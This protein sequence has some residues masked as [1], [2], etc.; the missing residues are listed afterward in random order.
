MSVEVVRIEHGH[1][2][3]KFIDFPH[4][5]YENDPY[6]VPEIYLSVSEILS[7]KKNPFFEHSEA[8]YF[9]AYRDQKLVGRIAAIHNKNYNE[10]HQSNVGFFGFFDF[11]DD[12]EVSGA[13]LKVAENWCKDKGLSSMLGPA[14]LT[15]NDTAGILIEGFDDPPVVQMTYNKP[16]YLQHLEK[17]GYKKEMDL[18]A[19]WI[20]SW[21]ASEKSIR[22]SNLI[23]ERLQKRGITFRSIR[24]NQFKSEIRKVKEIYRK[25]W[26]KNWGFVPPTDKEFDHLAEGL[27]MIIDDRYVYIAEENGQTI[28]FGVALPNIN[29]ITI[30][31]KKG[32]LFPFGILRLLLGKRKVKKVRVVLLGVLEEYRKMGIEA[33]FFAQFIQAARENNLLG[34]EASWVLENNDMMVK[35]AENLNGKKYKVYRI[36]NKPL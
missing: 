33:V 12:Y 3:K 34:G 28:A 8:E 23:K 13:L 4:T 5:L 1:S 35:A 11:I 22:L 14:N 6:Y 16:Y 20:P 25:A 36:Y 9:L 24:M 10:Y 26:E 32:R 19:Y 30:K 7:R 21:E 27:K 17:W 2:V 15:T 31:I 18:N 29:E